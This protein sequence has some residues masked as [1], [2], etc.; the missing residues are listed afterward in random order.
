MRK[1]VATALLSSTAFATV[2]NANDIY[3]DFNSD[4]FHFRFD[5]THASNGI[6]Y[7][8]QALFTS[9]Q[10]QVFSG[11]LWTKSKMGNNGALTGGLGGKIY[12]IDDKSNTYFALGLGGNLNY[13]FAE[14]S[15]LSLRA[16]LYYA[17]SMV[18]SSDYDN[19]TDVTL[20]M[21]YSLFENGEIY[22]GFRQL[23]S[24]HSNNYTHKM[25]DGA[26]IGIKLQF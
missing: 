1:I 16:A 24:D 9:E 2:A 11:G 5:A 6:Q 22:G 4:T 19:V 3:M 14:V 17:P 12:G 20:E 13:S 26:H 18:I 21:A 15:G 25:D 23:Q 7:S 10:G 8:G